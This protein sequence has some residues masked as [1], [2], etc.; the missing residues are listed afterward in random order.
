[1]KPHL[2]LS[3]L[4]SKRGQWAC[5]SARDNLRG[6]LPGRVKLPLGKIFYGATPSAAYERWKDY[7][8]GSA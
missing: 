4:I 8:V 7:H 5:C 2:W 3:K 1:M 6:T